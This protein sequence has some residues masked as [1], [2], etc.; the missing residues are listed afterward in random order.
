V[1]P[2]LEAVLVRHVRER[3]RIIS[4]GQEKELG[5]DCPLELVIVAFEAGYHVVG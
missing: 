1:A 3:P 5:G 4:P 2:G